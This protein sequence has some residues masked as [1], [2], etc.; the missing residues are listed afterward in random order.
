MFGFRL[1]RL[2]AGAVIA[3]AGSWTSIASAQFFGGNCGCGGQAIAPISAPIVTGMAMQTP[4]SYGNPCCTPCAV[5]VQ[6]VARYQ[7]ITETAYR[8]VQ[9]VDYKPVQKTAKAARVVTVQE[10]QDVTVY[11][12]VTEARTV[13]VPSYDYQQVTECRPVTVNQSY[14]RTVYQPVPKMSPC[15]YD[16]RTGFLGEMN[17]L[18]YSM[19]NSVTPNQVARRE[20]VPNVSQYS[21]PQTRTVAVPTSRQVT[22]N[23]ARVVPVQ[24][25]R[26]VA[27]QK[28][29][30]EDTTYTAYEP[31]TTTKKVAY[32]TTRMA[33]VPLDGSSSSATAAAPTPAGT[34]TAEG[35]EK[36]S[37]KSLSTPNELPLRHPTFSTEQ[38]TRE[39]ESV[40]SVPVAQRQDSSIIREAKWRPHQPR[41]NESLSVPP[42]SVAAN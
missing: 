15:Q 17:R 7:P 9:V 29:I 40:D 41:D 19:R 12:T 23:V 33:L 22:Y 10:E 27:V 25:K 8:D 30:W 37:V 26:Q 5:Q 14:W 6:P 18:A 4:V 39:V 36:G 13:N 32:T 21:V 34:Q 16:S 3:A 31:F 42:V 11:K 35:G 20:F 28:V 1:R 24:E 2:V 38:P